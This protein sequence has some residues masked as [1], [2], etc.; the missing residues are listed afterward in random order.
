RPEF[1]LNVLAVNM[2]FL[3]SLENFIDDVRYKRAR[4]RKGE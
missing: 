4:G 1:A 2:K 3:C